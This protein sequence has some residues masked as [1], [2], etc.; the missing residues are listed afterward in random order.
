MAGLSRA[1]LAATLVA[2]LA[3]GACG[4]RPLYGD[5]DGEAGTGAARLSSIEVALIPN[6]SGQ[7]LR[8]FLIQRLNPGG[9]PDEPAYRLNVAVREVERRLGVDS[10]DT[11]TRANLVVNSTARL[12]DLTTSAVVY[13]ARVDA[14]TSF[15]ILDDEF[16]TL[17]SRRA[18]RER[19][20][21]QIS[22]DI[23]T[24]VALYFQRRVAA[25]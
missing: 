20:L 3:V 21:E 2:S 14:I 16:A 8:T 18:A 10:T 9:R 6:R 11:A 12:T 5:L 4:F 17:A 19:A 24:R 22:E 23:R 13:D 25:R 1:L 15:N 7:L